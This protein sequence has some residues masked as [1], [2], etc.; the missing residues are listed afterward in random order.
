MSKNTMEIKILDLTQITWIYETYMILDFPKEEL[1]PLKAI[2]WMLEKGIYDCLG[3]YQQEELMAYAFFVKNEKRATLLLDYLAVTPTYRALGVGSVFI[4]QMKA[5]Y[6]DRLAI[7]LECESECTSPD[8]EQHQI[9]KRRIRFYLRNGCK[10][11]SVKSFLYDVE[12]EILCLH[13]KEQQIDQTAELESLYRLM[14]PDSVLDK[15]LRLWNRHQILCDAYQW[16]NQAQDWRDSASL[17]EALG[18]GTDTH[19]V[20]PRVISF[21]G[22]GGKSTTMYQLA[23]ELAE[24]GCYVVV[25]TS[26]HIRC[27]EDGWVVCNKTIEE[28]VGRGWKERIL[29]V[30]NLE[31]GTGKL[32]APDDLMDPAA[33]E[34]VLDNAGVILIEADGSK[35]YPLKVP[36]EHEPV[37]LGQTDMVVAC[38]GLTVLGR[39]F[40]DGCFRFDGYG[41]WLHRKASDRIDAEDTALVLMD[42]RGSRKGISKLSDCT[43][44][45]VLN[46]ADDEAVKDQ[47]AKMVRLLPEF[48]KSGCVMTGYERNEESN[49]HQR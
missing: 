19:Q 13:L 33:I 7:L 38:A 10:R 30:G 35:G 41:T 42:E 14:F 43:C 1:K 12:Y 26:T 5:H 6:S 25:T 39:T 29:T 34:R 44:R 23:D 4:G 17:C 32:T 9:R 37:L 18:I 45:I 21:V 3:L 48:M 28:A 16:E 2:V 49:E 47:A 8:E 15:H 11:T 46:Q 31:E 36:A 27:P 40:E 22:A 24:R 20:M